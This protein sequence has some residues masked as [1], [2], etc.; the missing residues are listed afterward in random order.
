ML[1]DFVDSIVQDKPCPI[2]VYR[3]LD[4]S[5]PGVCAA[6]SAESGLPVTIP[7]PRRF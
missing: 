4:Y 3:G 2:D 6:L 5:L 7:D 1:N